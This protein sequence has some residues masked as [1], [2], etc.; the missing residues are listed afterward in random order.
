M[1]KPP[2]IVEVFLQPGEWYFGDRQTRVRTLLGS[3]VS[4]TLWHPGLLIGG[5]C[6]YMLPERFARRPSGPDGKYADEAFW[7]LLR[8]VEKSGAALHEY[9]VKLFGGGN[10]FPATQRCEKEHIGRKNADFGRHLLHRHGLRPKA[11]DLGGNGH[12]TVLFDIWS[13]HVWVRQFL[14]KANA[15]CTDCEIR[16]ACFDPGRSEAA[17]GAVNAYRG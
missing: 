8:E 4:I 13:G 9:E 7:L 16:D 17:R 6:H 1:R 2:H 3:C 5:M 12:R 10:M 14:Q 11:A 15:A